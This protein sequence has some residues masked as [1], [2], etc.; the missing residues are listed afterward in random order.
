MKYALYTGCTAKESTPELLKSTLLVAKTLGIEIEIL[1]EASCCGAGH[2]QDFDEFLSLVLNARNICLAEKRGLKMVTLCNTCQ[3]MLE[4]TK[5][6]L[7]SDEKLKEK[8]NEKLGEL[9]YKYVGNTKI[10]H[11]L[12]AILEDVGFEEISK[13]IKRP[14]NMKIAPFYGCHIIRPSKTHDGD[15]LNENPYK[16]NAIENLIKV[17]MGESVDYSTK[18][19]C[20]GF[21][22]DLQ[23]TPVSE[24]LTSNILEDATKAGAEAIVTPCPLCHLNLDVKQRAIAK[25]ENKDFNIPVLHLPEMLALAFGYSAEEI[26]LNHHVVDVKF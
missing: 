2:L 1:N 5:R 20:C 21:H 23:N 14:L 12:Y 4:N 3:L 24:K 7:D 8:V 15:N 18:L 19:K 10:Q 6:K 26:G 16:P 22:V 13:H 11:F 17:L 9:G 25:R